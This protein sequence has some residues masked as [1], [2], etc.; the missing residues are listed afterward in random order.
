MYGSKPA[1]E[2]PK[3]AKKPAP[4]AAE[5]VASAKSTP[6]GCARARR[7]TAAKSE[8]PQKKPVTRKPRYQV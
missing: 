7:H 3:A 6:P 8:E 2:T 1:A 4:K 5:P